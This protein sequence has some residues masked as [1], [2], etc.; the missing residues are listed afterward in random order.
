MCVEKAERA[1]ST[2]GEVQVPPIHLGR[3]INL[4]HLAPAITRKSSEMVTQK[5]DAILHRT[6][7][8]V[9]V[10]WCTC[11]TSVGFCRDRGM[12]PR[13]FRMVFRVCSVIL[14]L[15]VIVS[16]E[17]K[18]SENKVKCLAESFTRIN[19]FVAL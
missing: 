4:S 3:Q 5:V 2:G 13:F 14:I 17:A 8:Y 7:N 10:L 19:R 12:Q 16:V 9:E 15:L 18:L 11:V 1:S 6:S